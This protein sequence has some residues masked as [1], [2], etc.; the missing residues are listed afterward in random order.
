MKISYAFIDVDLSKSIEECLEYVVPRLSP[1][2]MIFMDELADKDNLS[3]FVKFGFFDPA[4]F[5]IRSI[6]GK[7]GNIKDGATRP[8]D[9]HNCGIIKKISPI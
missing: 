2:G 6:C 3:T 9:H 7:T 8:E 1:G 5:E 4:K